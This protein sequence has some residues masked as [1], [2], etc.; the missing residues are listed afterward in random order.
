MFKYVLSSKLVTDLN[1]IT[2]VLL[3]LFI[4]TTIYVYVYLHVTELEGSRKATGETYLLPKSIVSIKTYTHTHIIC[5]IE[6]IYHENFL[7][8]LLINPKSLS[9]LPVLYFHNKLVKVSFEQCNIFILLAIKN[10][11]ISIEND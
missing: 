9:I 7:I 4:N 2:F 5:M 10:A 3:L 1:F 8:N 11:L 6:N